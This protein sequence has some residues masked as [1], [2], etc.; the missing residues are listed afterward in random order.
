MHSQPTVDAIRAKLNQKPLS[1]KKAIYAIFA[2]LCVLCVFGVSAFLILSHAEEAHEI[3]QLANLIVLFFG[4]VVTALITGQTAMDWRATSALQSI[5]EK[6][7]SNAEAPEEEVNE[8][9][10]K[11]RYYDDGK[12]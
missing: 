2:S 3:V 1:S 8:R 12:I 4:T 7:D 9:V 10:Y 11:P 5:D 6:I